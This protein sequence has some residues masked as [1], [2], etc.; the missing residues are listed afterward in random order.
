MRPRLLLLDEPAARLNDRETE[1]LA[2]P[3]RR[4]P[5]R[6]ITL[7][8]VEHNMDFMMSVAERI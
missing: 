5:E 2:G 7:L 6:G 8:L 3:I 4:L 1:E